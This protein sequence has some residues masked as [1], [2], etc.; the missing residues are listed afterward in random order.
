VVLYI[1]VISL[2]QVA[3]AEVEPAS[4]EKIIIDTDI[5][6][7]IDD[8]FAVALALRSPEVRVIGFSTAF[9]DT[10]ARAA[11]LD[12][13]L[14][15]SGNEALPVA[16]GIP[17]STPNE[18]G[19][20]APVSQKHYG[21]GSRFARSS[22][23][24]AVDFILE[25]IRRFPGQITL[26]AIGPLSNIG[27]LIDRDPASF[28]KLKRIVMMGGSIGAIKP[29]FG[30]GHPFGP[31]AEWNISNDIPSA[32]KLFRTGVPIYMI[33]LDS[34]AH[35][36]LDDVKRAILFSEG[37]PLTDSLAR[38][39]Q[40]WSLSS[41]VQIPVLYDAMAVA[42]VVNP[43]L[44]PVTPAHISIDDKGFTRSDAGPSNAY[45]CAHS[46]PDAFFSF[47]MRRLV[48]SRQSN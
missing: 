17:T 31:V 48:G 39:Y 15:E 14:G 33:P 43:E 25:Q 22:H 11:I 10:T 30:S 5:G 44:C 20:G 26:V 18:S 2:S 29:D 13:L 35:L 45:V 38:L 24:H 34:T 28:Q 32:Q 21:E 27:P 40:L 47:Y 36:Q 42:V 1:F 8:A 41:G 12:R 9:G 46:D 3:I 16:I 7:D 23:P 4:P 19:F 6:D 37:T